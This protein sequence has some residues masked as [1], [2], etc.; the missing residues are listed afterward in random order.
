[1]AGNTALI[2]LTGPKKLVSN[3]FRVKVRVTWDT[4]SSSTAPITAYIDCQH[5]YLLFSGGIKTAPSLEQQN[6]TSIL[7]NILMALATAA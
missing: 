5:R 1:M 3:W 4:P 2:T 7:P 6:K